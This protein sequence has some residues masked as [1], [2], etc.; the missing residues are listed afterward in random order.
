MMTKI[1]ECCHFLEYLDL[2][3][4][5]QLSN[6]VL[7]PISN[8]ENLEFLSISR[9]YKIDDDGIY[10]LLRCKNL[11]HLHLSELEMVTD[12]SISRL[13]FLKLKSLDISGTGATDDGNFPFKISYTSPY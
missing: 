8:L 13:N 5:E 12:D 4:C 7:K 1:C 9:C 10:F 2:D 6:V 11:R 3:Y